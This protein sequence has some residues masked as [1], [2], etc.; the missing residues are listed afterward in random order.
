MY[1][2]LLVSMGILAILS[3]AVITL[4]FTSY[5]TL[6]YTNA[7][8]NAKGIATEQMEQ[9]RN[10]PYASVGTV[11]GIPPGV[12]PQNQIIQRNGLNYTVKISIVYIDDP[13]DHQA[14]TDLLPT[15][16]KR[17]RVEVSWG[18]TAASN[19]DNVTLISD[20]S[21]NGVE[22][23]AGGGTLYILVFDGG[24]KPLPQANVTITAGSVN[25][26][27]NLTLQTDNFGSVTL[28][29]APACNNA[30]YRITAT[31][32]Y[33]TTD[34]TYSA[35]EVANPANPDL[36]VQE[37]Q[38]VPV[39][40]AIDRFSTLTFKST[41]DRNSNFAPLPNQQFRLVG[42]KSIGTDS[43]GQNVYKYNKT[44]ATDASGNLTLNN[45]EW[46][47]Y[48]FTPL[49][50]DYDLAGSNPFL[51]IKLLPNTTLN[52]SY[53]LSAHTANSLLTL[54]SD[55]GGN[56]VSSVSAKI[57]NGSYSASASAGLSTDPD[58]GQVFFGG[59][60]SGSYTLEATA[61]GFAYF[62]ESLNVSGQTVEKTTLMSQ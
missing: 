13:F 24:G 60:S 40:L 22:T 44:L 29:G 4:V 3:Q 50:P 33:Y 62:S 49:S 58:F 36:S 9:I 12:I 53:A 21:P 31:K 14:P 52:F 61:S 59:L 57:S 45:M 15:D 7:R 23:T 56:P 26:P 19:G 6:N 55:Q 18:G 16:Y 2:G 32:D 25:P 5:S 27:V 20:I 42:N 8:T 47:T 10:L 46:D 1:F 51:P 37:G 54:F 41:G 34:R 11:G 17:V 43:S 35:S 48:Q 28:P 30:C 39:S 38:V